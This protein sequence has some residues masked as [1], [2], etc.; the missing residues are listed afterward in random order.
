MLYTSIPYD[1]NWHIYIDGVEV[2]TY[3]SAE[4]LLA[5]DISAG[6]H[7]IELRYIHRQFYLG[8]GISAGGIAALIGLAFLE[9]FREKKWQQKRALTAASLPPPEEKA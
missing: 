9:K 5:A 2:P 4:A 6:E 1:A 3:E 7:T 8:L